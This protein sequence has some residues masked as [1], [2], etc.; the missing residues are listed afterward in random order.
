[1]SDYDYHKKTFDY[2]PTTSRTGSA[3]GYLFVAALLVLFFVGVFYFGSSGGEGTAPATTDGAST[4]VAPAT[5][6]APL[7]APVPDTQ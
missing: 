1:M 7:T 5:D 2:T 6:T 4:P 3:A